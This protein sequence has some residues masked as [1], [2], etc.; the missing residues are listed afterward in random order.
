MRK[1]L[2]KILKDKRMYKK[3][4]YKIGDIVAYPERYDEDGMEKVI[5]SRII[6]AHSLLEI[7]T[8]DDVLS[9]YYITEE[10]NESGA[11]FLEESEIMYKL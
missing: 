7:E 5:Q 6:E 1:N 9:W 11:D 8:K 4:K 10:V 2:Q 3:P